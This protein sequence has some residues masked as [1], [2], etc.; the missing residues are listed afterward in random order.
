MKLQCVLNKNPS[1]YSGMGSI[2]QFKK[3]NPHSMRIDGL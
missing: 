3:I 1:N 2:G